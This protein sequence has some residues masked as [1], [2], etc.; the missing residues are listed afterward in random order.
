MT[1][2][3]DPRTIVAI[4]RARNAHAEATGKWVSY[5]ED[6][7]AAE[8]EQLAREALGHLETGRWDDAQGCAEALASL[9]EENCKDELWREFALLVDEA[10]ETGRAGASFS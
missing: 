1:E 4:T 8:A 10:A 2:T 5:D 9:A 7:P 3:A 6:D